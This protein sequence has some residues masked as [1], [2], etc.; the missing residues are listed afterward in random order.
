MIIERSA[1]KNGSDGV[2]LTGSCYAEISG[3]TLMRNQKEMS[4]VV[5][6]CNHTTVEVN[7]EGMEIV[8]ERWDVWVGWLGLDVVR[9]RQSDGDDTEGMR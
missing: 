4:R 2:K 6:R 5:S 7:P 3:K 1:E 8:G 9:H